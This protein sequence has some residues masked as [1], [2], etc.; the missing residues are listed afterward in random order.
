MNLGSDPNCI[1]VMVKLEDGDA[2]NSLS[3]IPSLFS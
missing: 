1:K 2:Y 3:P